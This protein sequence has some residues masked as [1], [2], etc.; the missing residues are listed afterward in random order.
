VGYFLGALSLMLSVYMDSFN[1]EITV[2]LYGIF[3]G[4]G[5]QAIEILDLEKSMLA[6]V[7]QIF[8]GKEH[9]VKICWSL[10]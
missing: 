4:L 7:L 5:G 2:V 6:Q 10:I 9:L 1:L 8:W 3:H